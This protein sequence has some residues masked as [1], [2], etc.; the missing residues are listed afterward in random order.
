MKNENKVTSQIDNQSNNVSIDSK[1]LK[2]KSKG[3][4]NKKDPVKRKEK[5]GNYVLTDYIKYCKN[6]KNF[7]NQ[8]E[9]AAKEKNR[10][11]PKPLPDS[12]PDGA[13]VLY[14]KL[15]PAWTEQLDKQHIKTL[16]LTNNGH[17]LWTLVSNNKPHY[18]GAMVTL[19]TLTVPEPRTYGV[20]NK[21]RRI[22]VTNESFNTPTS[23]KNVT[24][25]LFWVNVH[26]KFVYSLVDTGSE[27]SS[28]RQDIVEQLK[29]DILPLNCNEINYSMGLA[30]RIPIVGTVLLNVQFYD[31]DLG[32]HP[33]KVIPR[34]SDET[35]KLVLGHD[36]LVAKELIYCGDR[37]ILRGYYNDHLMWT[38]QSK[39]NM[40]TRIISNISCRAKNDFK[41]EPNQTVEL[42]VS[43]NL[44]KEVLI[45]KT[46][47][48]IENFSYGIEANLIRPLNT[49]DVPLHE[50]DKDDLR[51]YTSYPDNFYVLN[52]MNPEIKLENQSNKLIN[53]K[54]D[55]LV[56]KAYHIRIIYMNLINIDPEIKNKFLILRNKDTYNVPPSLKEC[57]IKINTLNCLYQPV[58]I[59]CDENT[60]HADFDV[61]ENVI[62]VSTKFTAISEN[63]SVKISENETINYDY[64]IIDNCEVKITIDNNDIQ[65]D[66]PLLSDFNI[67]DEYDLKDPS[68]WTKDLLADSVTLRTCSDEFKEKFLALLWEYKETVSNSTTV[69]PSTLPEV[70]LIPKSNEIIHVPQYKFGTATALEVEAIVTELFRANIVERSNSLFNN[71]IHLVRKKDGSGRVCVDMRRVNSILERPSPSP[72]PSVEDVMSELHGMNVYSS[73]NLLSGFFQINLAPESRKY[74]AFTSVHRY[75][76]VRLPSGCSASPIEFTRLLNVALQDMLVPI[77]LPG[78][79]KPRIH[80][81][82]YVDDL[83][84]FSVNHADHLLLLRMLFKLLSEHNLKLKLEKCTFASDSVTFLGFK[85]NQNYVEKEQKYIEKILNLPK[86]D[87]IKDVMRLLGSCVY[88]H[89]FI[90]QYANIARP[91]TNLA[92]TCKRKMRGKVE[93]TPDMEVAYNKLREHV[94]KEVKLTYP[95]FSD[96]AAPLTISTDASTVATGGVLQQ[97]QNGVEHI[98]AFTSSTFTQ[99]QRHYTVTELEILAIKASIRAFHPFIQNRHFVLKSDHAPLLHLV[100]M[101][102]FNGRIARTLEF[103]SNYD[104]EV[105][106]VAGEN[107]T[108]PDML[109]RAVIIVPVNK[110][111]VGGDSLIFALGQGR[112]NLLHDNKPFDPHDA[113]PLRSLLFLEIDQHKEKYGL[114]INDKN[115]PVWV[116]HLNSHYLLPIPFMQAFANIYGIDVFMYYGVD[117]PIIFK[118]EKPNPDNKHILIQNL[119]NNYFHLLKYEDPNINTQIKYIE[120]IKNNKIVPFYNLVNIDEFLTNDESEDY[121]KIIFDDFDA[122]TFI[123]L[124]KTDCNDKTDEHI[125]QRQKDITTIKQNLKLIQDLYN[126]HQ[127]ENQVI[128]HTKLDCDKAYEQ[129]LNGEFKEVHPQSY[130]SLYSRCCEHEYTT[131]CFIPIVCG[132]LRFCANLDSGSTCSVLSLSVANK[133]FKQ[134]QLKKLYDTEINLVC[135]GGLTQVVNTRIVTADISI[136]YD[137]FVRYYWQRNLV[138]EG[139]RT[140][141]RC[142]NRV[143]YDEGVLVELARLKHPRFYTHR[144]LPPVEK[145]AILP[146]TPEPY[147][148]LIDPVGSAEI[149]ASFNKL[150]VNVS[151]LPELTLDHFINTIDL[152]ALQ[153]SNRDLRSL[154]KIMQYPNFKLPPYLAQ[155]IH[156]KNHLML[157][158]NIIYFK[159]EPY[160]PVPV[161]PTNCII[162]MA[163]RILDKYSHCG[164][165]KLV[166]WVKTIAYHVKLSEHN[167]KQIHSASY[168]CESHGAIE[169]MNRTSA[170]LLRVHSADTLDWPSILQEAISG[171]NQSRHETLK[172]SPAEFLLKKPHDTHKKPT[173]TSQETQYW[174]VG[175][176]SFESYKRGTLVMKILPKIGNRDLYKLQNL[177]IGPYYILKIHNGGTSYSIRSVDDHSIIANVHHSQLRLWVPPDKLL[178]KNPDFYAYYNYYRPLTPLEAMRYSEECE[179]LEEREFTRNWRPSDDPCDISDEE[180]SDEFSNEFENPN[181]ESSNDQESDEDNDGG[182]SGIFYP[183]TNSLPIAS[184]L[185]PFGQIP[186]NSGLG[187]PNPPQ[188]VDRPCYYSSSPYINS[189]LPPGYNPAYFSDPLTNK[190][191]PQN[192]IPNIS[193]SQ[194]KKNKFV[195]PDLTKPPP[196]IPPLIDNAFSPINPIPHIFTPTPAVLSQPPPTHTLESTHTPQYQ[197]R[198]IFTPPN[199]SPHQ[200]SK[201]PPPTSLPNY[202][203]NQFEFV[204]SPPS[205]KPSPN[206]YF[207]P[208]SFNFPL[209]NKSNV[210]RESYTPPYSGKFYQ[211]LLNENINSQGELSFSPIKQ[212]SFPSSRTNPNLP[213][214]EGPSSGQ[215]VRKESGVVSS[216]ENEPAFQPDPPSPITDNESKTKYIIPS[217]TKMKTRSQTRLEMENQ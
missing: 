174:R 207:N 47:Y 96:G 150:N 85:F 25:N 111:P 195:M 18:P 184:P 6:H 104:F 205:H 197:P 142:S 145:N 38:Y 178:M 30:G 182:E 166:D 112:D 90:E 1:K 198:Q 130:G 127:S 95:D 167:I 153:S 9:E 193:N 214:N 138:I 17:K 86:P 108:L 196:P 62:N 210:P 82:I 5:D 21:T 68:E 16:E 45:N 24:P 180:L 116:M 157:I 173:L 40:V 100:S 181:N 31:I 23:V 92:T 120:Y 131:E 187:D 93:W 123:A 3:R 77:K 103:L 147:I 102:P 140:G 135:A 171:Y 52:F 134:G 143:I 57:M 216:K 155:Y 185:P 36:F 44:P 128:N 80:C 42:P 208:S 194:P 28:I 169:R 98:I 129:E 114:T 12:S 2:Y 66:D 61:N 177:Y 137:V 34:I 203:K 204:K 55:S 125:K 99:T 175:N 163:L 152:E 188:Q 48:D 136:G 87:T 101:R 54:T 191:P 144:H 91:L 213:L 22:K 192:S 63:S 81:K 75:Q 69:A 97:L 199:L 132:N 158:N 46:N 118:S 49:D 107:N 179:P 83:F 211:N 115:K 215:G 126:T 37:R 74:T 13:T 109:S 35:D 71:P 89:R 15:N 186:Q 165:D 121:D 78:D 168:H 20:I 122:Q 73:L 189:V 51:K 170:E 4:K 124:T 151:T 72:L 110:S 217:P 11:S 19:Q 200:P 201:S 8:K 176:P 88:I 172:T 119:A 139:D 50:S 26:N 32:R 154:R 14:K 146:V 27:Y 106:W 117:T 65:Q 209:N 212:P 39:E 7:L 133:L 148:K 67:P 60:V 141:F 59:N 29:I 84:L 70:H 41:V 160:E 162:T 33:F 164:R 76:Y 94:A 183:L 149:D 64:Q 206:S 156:V 190:I 43:V 58:N 105:Q 159:K 53:Y 10:P 56:G 79:D 161:L 113:G 202:D